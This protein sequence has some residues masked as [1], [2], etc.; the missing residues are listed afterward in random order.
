MIETNPKESVSYSIGKEENSSNGL[1]KLVI[2]GCSSG[3]KEAVESLVPEIELGSSAVVVVPHI[4][5]KEIYE[6]LRELGVNAVGIDD[7][8]ELREGG[9]Y[10]VDHTYPGNMFTNGR[11]VYQN[12]MSLFKTVKFKNG[13]IHPVHHFPSQRINYAFKSAAN[14][15]HGGVVGVVLKGLG[16]DGMSGVKH[17]KR[18]GGEVLVQI[19]GP[20]DEKHYNFSSQGMA[21]NAQ[22]ATQVDFAGPLPELVTV[23]NGYLNGRI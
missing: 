21:I 19:D 14:N 16:D 3:G 2:I 10:V 12:I 8:V 11:R 1:E 13:R 15:Y 23:L 22:K 9:I 7:E 20:Y 18:H 6:S 4:Q 5:N 17:I